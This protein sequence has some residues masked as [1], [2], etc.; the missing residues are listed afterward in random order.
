MKR[1]FF[2]RKLLTINFFTKFMV[3]A[4]KNLS[5]QHVYMYILRFKFQGK[6]KKLHKSLQ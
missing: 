6:C 1:I 5:S 4:V 2:L 3:V